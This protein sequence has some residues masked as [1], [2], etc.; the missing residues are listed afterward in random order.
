MYDEHNR[1]DTNG[2]CLMN[3]HIYEKK[4]PLI[5]NTLHDGV[6]YNDF[7]SSSKSTCVWNGLKIETNLP[8]NR[9]ESV[10]MQK[11]QYT[12]QSEEIQSWKNRFIL[13]N[14]PWQHFCG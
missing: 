11:I 13:I 6:G 3:E 4:L 10:K 9:Y 1:Y 2:G 7:L 5:P 8:C 14:F 12:T